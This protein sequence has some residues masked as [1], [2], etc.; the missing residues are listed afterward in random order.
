MFKQGVKLL[1]FLLLLLLLLIN[2]KSSIKARREYEHTPRR[3]NSSAQ[4]SGPRR[5]LKL[6]S[7]SYYASYDVM[8]ALRWDETRRE[9]ER[10]QIQV[11]QL[12][13]ERQMACTCLWTCVLH[14]NQWMANVF[15]ISCFIS[16]T[17]ITLYIINGCVWSCQAGTILAH[18]YQ[19]IYYS[20]RAIW[21]RGT[22]RYQLTR[23]WKGNLR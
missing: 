10:D 7:C 21:R 15:R 16:S 5:D 18:W 8:R 4:A 2:V 23:G 19:C 13:W 12:S 1:R 17:N 11:I 6:L 3:L 20:N 9:K 14:C 22:G